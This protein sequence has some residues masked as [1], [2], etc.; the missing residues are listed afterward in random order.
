MPLFWVA[1]T[2]LPNFDNIIQKL[3]GSMEHSIRQIYS[4]Y[5]DLF[6]GYSIEFKF[7]QTCIGILVLNENF[8]D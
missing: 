2:K 3:H 8:V 4:L 6:L 7:M 1:D 5:I